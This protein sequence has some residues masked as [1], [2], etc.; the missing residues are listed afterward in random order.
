MSMTCVDLFPSNWPPGQG[1]DTTTTFQSAIETLATAIC[2]L[3]CQADE[4]KIADCGTDPA[5]FGALYTNCDSPPDGAI[6]IENCNDGANIYY[7]DVETTSWKMIYRQFAVG[8]D[9]DFVDNDNPTDDELNALF[10]GNPPKYALVW[11]VP[12]KRF[13][14]TRTAGGTWIEIELGLR[15]LDTGA[16]D[17]GHQTFQTG[18][19]WVLHVNNSVVYNDTDMPVK[20]GDEVEYRVHFGYRILEFPLDFD[21]PKDTVSQRVTFS[22]PHATTTFTFSDLVNGFRTSFTR[23]FIANAN[24]VTCKVSFEGLYN[25]DGTGWEWEWFIEKIQ[26]VVRR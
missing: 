5:D 25:G 11:I 23:S 24:N 18:G 13:W 21:G 8:L 17:S 15:K 7:Y 16:N 3:R 12:T 4:I 2:G 22:G 9:A 6:V 1:C 14:Y 20:I 26:V 10:G 19:T